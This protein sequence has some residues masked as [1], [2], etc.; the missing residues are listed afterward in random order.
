MI[1]LDTSVVVPLIVPET[2]SSRARSWFERLDSAQTKALAVSAWVLTEFTSAMGIKVRNREITR[3]QGEAARALL[4]DAL[5][6]NVSIIEVTPTDFRLAETMLR[7]FSLGLRAG[8][9]L[10]LATASRC[11]A[12]QFVSL[13][14]KL[15]NVA[16]ALGLSVT[17]I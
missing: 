5:L 4:E 16:A 2:T 7:E 3:S 11:A 10:H 9:A 13:D 8:D 15:C 12:Q 14:R 6:P 1:Y 17:R